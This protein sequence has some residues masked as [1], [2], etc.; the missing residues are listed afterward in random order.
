MTEDGVSDVISHAAPTFCIQ[1]PMFETIVASQRAR[2]TGWRN[3]L[4]AEADIAGQFLP[5]I[6]APVSRP[7]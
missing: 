4:Q 6:T 2:K 3:G 5:T 7:W 1:V